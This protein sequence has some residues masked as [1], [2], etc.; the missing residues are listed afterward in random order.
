MMTLM[1]YAHHQPQTNMNRIDPKMTCCEH[2]PRDVK[3]N[4][5][6]KCEK[7]NKQVWLVRF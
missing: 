6:A 2:K 4:K 3:T 1:S 7:V 5:Q